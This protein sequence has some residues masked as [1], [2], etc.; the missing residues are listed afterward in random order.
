MISGMT[1]GVV[2]E[3]PPADAPKGDVVLEVVFDTPWMPGPPSV[4]VLR[5][6]RGSAP[7]RQMQISARVW[8]SCFV[9]PQA[10]ERGFV[11]GRIEQASG[12]P[13][14]RLRQSLTREQRGA[15]RG[16]QV[17]DLFLD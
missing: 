15:N 4:T 8:S 14:L 17:S 16:R 3:Q 10:G 13:V 1:Y 9:P 7:A 6:V 11:V 12:K 5:A 2:F